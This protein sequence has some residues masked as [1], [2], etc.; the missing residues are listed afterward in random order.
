M[1]LAKFLVKEVRSRR[2]DLTGKEVGGRLEAGGERFQNRTCF[3][4]DPKSRTS[5]VESMIL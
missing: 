1:R 4:V 3:P 5:V 2:F